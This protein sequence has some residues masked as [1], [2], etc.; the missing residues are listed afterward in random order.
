MGKYQARWSRA[1]AEVVLGELAAS[2]L[3]LATFARRRGLDAGRLSRW[4]RRIEE[5]STPLSMVELTL[6]SRGGVGSVGSSVEGRLQAEAPLHCE[7]QVHCPSGHVVH[8]GIMA[9]AEGLRCVLGVLE[10]RR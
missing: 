9:L 7:F 6:A 5:E 4:R 8:L 10:A 2:G 3:P 1:E